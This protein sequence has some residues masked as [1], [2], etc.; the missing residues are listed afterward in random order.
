MV[1]KMRKQLLFHIVVFIGLVANGQ[2]LEV[3]KLN[4]S[5]IDKI[6]APTKA[7]QLFRKASAIDTTYAEAPYNLGTTLYQENYIEEAFGHLK[8]AANRSSQPD[9]SHKAFH[10]IGN[11]YMQ[12]E[13]YDNAIE[14]YKQALR[15]NPTDEETRYNLALAKKKKEEQEQQQEQNQDQDQNQ[16]QEQQEQ[17]ENEENE[18]NKENDQEDKEGDQEKEGD[19]GDSKEKERESEDE[20]G[21][22]SEKEEQ[23]KGQGDQKQEQGKRPEDKQPQGN[24]KPQELSKQQIENLLQALQNEENKVQEK[25]NAKKVQGR[26]LKVE[27]DW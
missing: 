23:K 21:E 7:E 10:N 16:D 11:V 2:R 3:E 6:S 1:S 4:N 17:Q 20:K 9:L 15:N 8:E 22:G 5:G 26:K 19:Q 24:P 13:E 27:K 12:K 14:A 18:E 25:M